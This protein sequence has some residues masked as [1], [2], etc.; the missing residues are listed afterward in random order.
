MLQG[1][2]IYEGT[3]SKE[4]L[5]ALKLKITGK[6]RKQL[7]ELSLMDCHEKMNLY[8]VHRMTARFFL[9]K[10]SE[11]EKKQLHLRAAQYF[12][13]LN[14]AKDKKEI[15]Y[16][17]KARRHYLEAEEWDRAAK[18]T[19]D[20]DQYLTP[21]GYVQLSY[22]LINEIENLDYSREI[23]LLIYQRLIAFSALFGMAD[24]VISRGEKLL[25]TYK[26]IKDKKGMAQSLGHIAMALESKRKYDDALKKFEKSKQLYD[27]TG[28]T[29]AAAFT[30]IEM[31]KI[32]QKRAKY[33]DALTDFE[34]ALALAEKGGNPGAIAESLHNIGQVHEAKGEL[35]TA[36]KDYQRARELREKIG[37]EKGM[38][39]ELHQI[40]NIF[41]LKGDSD[42]AFDNYQQSLKLAENKNDLRGQGYSLGQLG[43]I[44]QR[45][46]QQDEALRQYRKSL[47]AF[48]KLADQRGISASLHQIGRIHQDQGKLDQALENY[49]KSLEIR[50]KSADMQGMA[51]GHGQLGMLYYEKKEYKEA[52]VSSVKSFLLFSRMG[53]PG[54]KLA[55]KTIRKIEDKLPKEEF[56]AVLKEYNI[57]PADEPKK[58]EKP[59]KK[60]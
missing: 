49:K 47:Q 24:Q 12:E 19:F 45:R 28:D 60:K 15:E 6:D 38:A 48:E 3:V 25:K 52:L 56:N 44:Y 34:K 18:L 55:Q 58:K 16:E 32:R 57:T 21:K 35:D 7:V 37:D 41:F 30:L 51:V 20:L 13:A 10:V 14:E 39:A 33:D 11:A 53:A 26:E 4:A 43:L 23:R 29:Q 8:R 36:L 54:A 40:G 5:H 22:D 31:G 59:A 17:I 27:E 1:L 46:G 9:G 2:S 42:T 50:E